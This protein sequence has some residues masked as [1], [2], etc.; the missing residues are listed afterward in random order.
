MNSYSSVLNTL[1]IAVVVVACLFFAR[2]V[3][4]PVT[5]AGILSFMLAPV[6]RMLQNFRLPRAL[7]VI[8]VVLSAFAA[9]FALGTLITRE[10]T[11]LASDLPRYQATISK[12]IQRFSGSGETGM[13]GTLRRAEKVIEELD[14]EI[15]NEKV[16]QQKLIPVEVHAPSGGP[17]QTLSSLISPL[18]SPLAMAGLIVVLVIFI[19]LQREDLRNRLISLAGSTDIPH[20]TAAIDD[21]AH[22][23]SRLFLTQL[24]INSGFAVIIGLGLW[25]SSK[26]FPMGR[27]RRSTSIYS[28]H[29]F[30]PWPCLPRGP[31]SVC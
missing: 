27:T 29:R 7:A 25:W 2:E 4:I 17:L 15:S 18:L 20:T 16:S 30:N 10:V 24:I 12:K 21:A 8:V 14:T 6:V 1:L 13:A 26:S 11:Q 5:L 22:R 23:L 31:C 9:I 3:L 28:I 19:L